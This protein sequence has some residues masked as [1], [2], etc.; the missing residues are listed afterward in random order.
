LFTCPYK[1]PSKAT[2]DLKK[3]FVRYA[4]YACYAF[5][6]ATEIREY[7]F[8]YLPGFN[9]FVLIYTIENDFWYSIKYI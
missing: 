9:Y 8:K 4:K 1:A 3:N 7:L 5:T 2:A 6:D